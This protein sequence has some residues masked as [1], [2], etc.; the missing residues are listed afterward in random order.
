M[1]VK[2]PSINRPYMVA[3]QEQ[4]QH[5]VK[6]LKS[7]C[8]PLEVTMVPRRKIS[9][10]VGTSSEVVKIVV[11]TFENPQEKANYNLISDYGTH[12]DSYLNEL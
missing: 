12:I 5:P 8:M 9:S 1:G 10:N 3:E 6:Y 4:E 7:R 11:P 2:L